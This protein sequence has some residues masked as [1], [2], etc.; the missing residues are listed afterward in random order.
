VRYLCLILLAL[1][2]RAHGQNVTSVDTTGP[3]AT[4]NTSITKCFGDSL[5]TSFVIVIPNAVALHKH[6]THSEHV[7]V[8]EG[9]GQMTLGD[10]LIAIHKGDLVFIKKNTLHAAKSTGK[11][12]LKV[13]SIQAPMFDGTDR[14]MVK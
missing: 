12:P 3:K 9:E 14:V 13:L 8:L 6:V 4:I 10:S 5:S 1:V 2:Y 7:L 11:M